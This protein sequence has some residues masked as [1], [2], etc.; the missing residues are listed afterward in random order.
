MSRQENVQV[1]FE[2]DQILFDLC[3][4]DFVKVVEVSLTNRSS[5]GL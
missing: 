5:T 3:K 2:N 1:S 4:K